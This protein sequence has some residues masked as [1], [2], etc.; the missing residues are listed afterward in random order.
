MGTISTLYREQDLAYRTQYA[1]IKERILAAR[2]LLPGTPGTLALRKGTGRAYWYRVYYPVPGK[3]SEDLVCREGDESALKDMRERM[4][5]SSWVGSQ[6]SKLRKLGF[7]VSDKYVGRVLL[8]LHNKGAFEAGLVLVGTLG[9]MAWLNEL[10]ASAVAARTLDIDL[11]RAR[12]LKL[13]MPLSFMETMLA[14]EL[15]FVQVPGLPSTSPSTSVKLRGTRGLRVDLLA[16]GRTLGEMVLVPELQWC[17]QGIP[18][19][20]YLLN[21]PEPAAALA[22]GHCI[23]VRLPQAA[24][25]V[26]HKLYASTQRKGFAEKAEKDR[27]QALVLG[28]ALMDSDPDALEQAFKEAPSTMIHPVRPLWDLLVKRCAVHESL[29]RVLTDCLS[30][31]Q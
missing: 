21:N 22:G 16:P 13:A 5:F 3:Q 31:G 26:C 29:A 23:P 24:R 19:Y 2:T 30:R 10:G 15:P 8:E 11:G 12:P 4:E 6:V 20:D 25:L 17:A 14:T 28:A 27:L 7:Q 9:Y 18:Y 1:E